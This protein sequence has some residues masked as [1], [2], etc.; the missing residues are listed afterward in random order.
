MGVF[1]QIHK[2]NIE[3]FTINNAMINLWGMEYLFHEKIQK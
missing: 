2:K 1:I 3:K